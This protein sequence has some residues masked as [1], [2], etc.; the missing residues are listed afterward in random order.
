MQLDI[1]E[2]HP[3][4]FFM[5][6]ASHPDD[7]PLNVE[8]TTSNGMPLTAVRLSMH[9]YTTFSPSEVTVGTVR[10]VA[11][12]RLFFPNLRI[13]TMHDL[14]VY[15]PRDY[16]S[17]K[18]PW[19]FQFPKPLEKYSCEFRLRKDLSKIT[20]DKRNNS[21]YR[22]TGVVD[23]TAGSGQ[24]VDWWEVE[25]AISRLCTLLSLASGQRVNWLVAQGTD[26]KMSAPSWWLFRRHAISEWNGKGA[27]IPIHWNAHC[28]ARLMECWPTI[29]QFSDKQVVA[30]RQAIHLYLQSGP[31]YSF[32][33][34][35]YCCSGAFEV[36][37]SAF[38]GGRDNNY[39][40]DKSV[41]RKVQKSF[42]TWAKNDFLPHVDADLEEEIRRSLDIKFDQLNSRYLSGKITTMA[43]ELNLSYD[44]KVV[45]K[46]VKIRNN[47]THG[48]DLSVQ[49]TYEPFLVVKDMED[50]LVRIILRLL[51]YRG[52]Y[53]GYERKYGVMKNVE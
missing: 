27:V 7:E 44:N 35:L 51:N 21:Q 29:M 31:T 39:I 4:E 37:F 5:H 3:L 12:V 43:K 28:F 8:G 53:W 22:L 46:F 42:K 50:L 24:L 34:P 13:T 38:F 47:A 1:Q 11:R 15:G 30:L 10:P 52:Q 17:V 14:V 49:D 23:I 25:E 20:V 48:L 9:N 41:A 16:R 18:R 26:S 32:P 45:A 2:T 6:V 40:T 36:L 19:L 33:V